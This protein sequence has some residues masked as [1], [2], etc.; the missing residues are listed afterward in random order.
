MWTSLSFTK[1][2]SLV[3]LIDR[4][5]TGLSASKTLNSSICFGKLVIFKLANLKPRVDGR[6]KK[7]SFW[8]EEFKV[9]SSVKSVK[10]HSKAGSYSL[11]IWSLKFL[12]RMSLPTL[13]RWRPLRFKWLWFVFLWSIKLH[14]CW[15]HNSLR[16]LLIR[17][18]FSLSWSASFRGRIADMDSEV[19][20]E[21]DST[22]SARES[23]ESVS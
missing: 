8:L 17:E 14:R 2:S 15:R 16:E 4:T 19:L 5:S 22:W 23:M 12:A 3:S 21:S 20:G 18:M 11:L 1:L 7:S 9:R 10:S 13:V 6:K